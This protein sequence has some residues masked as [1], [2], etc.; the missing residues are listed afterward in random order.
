MVTEA[1]GDV[2]GALAAAPRRRRPD[3]P[4]DRPLSLARG[5]R[6]RRALRARSSREHPQTHT[7]VETMLD[8][9]SRTGMRELGVRALLHGAALGD[10]GTPRAAAMLPSTSTTRC[11]PVRSPAARDRCRAAAHTLA[12][13]E[14]ACRWCLP[15]FAK[16]AGSM[17]GD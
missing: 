8:R 6:P 10:R 15:T 5:L 17:V 16:L 9:A 1:S 13:E 11:S 3:Q 14:G 4:A 12:H 2:D 7:W